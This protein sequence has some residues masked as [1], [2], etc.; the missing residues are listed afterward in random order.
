[1]EPKKDDSIAHKIYNYYNWDKN[2]R[3]KSKGVY[4]IKKSDI[5][6][7]QNRIRYKDLEKFIQG[8]KDNSKLEAHIA[9]Y[10]SQND[11]DLKEKKEIYL[12]KIE[13][14]KNENIGEDRIRIDEKLYEILKNM[15][16]EVKV[17]EDKDPKLNTEKKDE[18]KKVENK[19]KK[20]EES[21]KEKNEEKG[22]NTQTE[23]KKEESFKNDE[24]E[25]K[26]D[27]TGLDEN[28]KEEEKKKKEEEE[29]KKQEELKKAE[30]EK[31]KQ[32]E[33]KREK[34]KEEKEHKEDKPTI[35]N[36]N[37][38]KEI[39]SN[40]E[41]PNLDSEKG[42]SPPNKENEN[43]NHPKVQ[44]SENLHEQVGGEINKPIDINNNIPGITLN[45]DNEN[46]VPNNVGEDKDKKDKNKPE[47]TNEINTNLA[48][49]EIKE[50]N[51][52]SEAL[53]SGQKDTTFLN[54]KTEG[55]G[56]PVDEQNKKT[57]L[58]E[59][60]TQSN[61]ENIENPEVKENQ[62]DTNPND[63]NTHET[64]EEINQ[65]QENR[66]ENTINTDNNNINANANQN[67]NPM[68]NLELMIQFQQFQQKYFNEHG[69]ENN[70]V[71]NYPLYFQNLPPQD[72]FPE[73]KNG[74]IVLRTDL[75]SLGLQNVGA[76]CYM[77]ATLECL[78]HIKELSEHLLSAFYFRFP[79]DIEDYSAKHKLSIQ[80][81]NILSQVYFPKLYNNNQKFYAPY[82]FK[83]LISEMNP[84]FAGVQANDA[85]DLLQFILETMHSELKMATQVFVEYNIDQRNQGM[86]MKYFYDSYVTQNKSP[87]HDYL[88]GVNKIQSLCLNCNTVKYNFQSYNLLYFPLKEAK[89]CAILKKK[90][91][92]PNF[93]E[94]NYILNLE[95]CFAHNEK[96]EKFEGDNQM[97]CNDCFRLADA[98]YQS[99]LFTAPTVLSIV[100]NRG[101]GNK[102]FTEDFIFGTELDIKKYIHNPNALHGKY[103]LIGMVVH[104]GTNDMGGHFIAYCRMDKHSK[105]FCYND[106][107]VYEEDDIDSKLN[108]NCPYIL[109]YH[110]DN[111]YVPP[112]PETQ[113]INIQIENKE[114]IKKEN[115]KE[116][117]EHKEE[118]KEEKKEDIINDKE[119]KETGN[120]INAKKQ[121]KD[122]INNENNENKNDNNPC[123]KDEGNNNNNKEAVEIKDGIKHDVIKE[124]EIKEGKKIEGEDKNNLSNKDKNEEKEKEKN[125]QNI[126]DKKETKE[127]KTNNEKPSEENGKT[128]SGN[129][130]IIKEEK[131]E[132]TKT[133]DKDKKEDPKLPGEINNPIPEGDKDKKED[134]KLPGKINNP[135]PEGDNKNQNKEK[136]EEK[137]EEIPKFENP[138]TEQKQKEEASAEPTIEKNKEEKKEANP[139][140]EQKDEKKEQIPGEK[141][142]ENPGQDKEEGNTDQK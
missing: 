99:S 64:Q 98:E 121:N 54:K 22:N 46:N 17:I 42:Q 106:A 135:I 36:N 77:N 43:Q 9:E 83:N 51:L 136:E 124:E 139:N 76:T 61:P 140:A 2:E 49:N 78:I 11:I 75:K 105:W 130:E 96:T 134:Q 79:K 15:Q 101:R 69:S 63:I 123:P 116:D 117:E 26:K 80:Y 73:V 62:N 21:Q 34:E 122:N 81:V 104:S 86:A 67:Q 91:E 85:K 88:Y 23:I 14:S 7:F 82:D 119:E 103:Y 24:G 133:D 137:K 111:E 113:N 38:S 109:F 8:K 65:E 93:N 13:E 74:R 58:E 128:I 84:L 39:N 33:L 68:N 53:S 18:Y 44:S 40:P 70:F 112:K 4:I 37:D 108:Q 126:D 47:Q 102:D 66:I 142:K 129:E 27:E 138:N 5:I 57:K 50:D 118:K 31:I 120:E 6:N 25:K 45:E 35:E 60:N 95:D 48:Q 114:D 55:E 12:S 29:L 100:L 52:I 125:E 90:E 30:E 92:D 28:I 127:E 10:Y 19:E 107:W 56:I 94:T 87:V 1:M 41:I 97:Y 141:P 16:Y 132:D 20:I 72:Y 3:E 32:E 131:K 110:Y 71:N 89:R 59:I 115:G